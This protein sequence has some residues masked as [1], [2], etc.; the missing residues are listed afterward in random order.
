M[1]PRGTCARAGRQ[2]GTSAASHSTPASVPLPGCALPSLFEPGARSAVP[3]QQVLAYTIKCGVC[4]LHEGQEPCQR[5]QVVP[6]CA[7]CMSW[8]ARCPALTHHD[9]CPA[10]RIHDPQTYKTLSRLLT[11]AINVFC[12]Y[13]LLVARLYRYKPAGR[14]RDFIKGHQKGVIQHHCSC[15]SD[16][17]LFG[18]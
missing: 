6:S 8:T 11:A 17:N 12:G 13:P 3:D 16:T 7:N 9:T 15:D 14:L 4:M 2:P 1:S 10:W 18:Q 5:V